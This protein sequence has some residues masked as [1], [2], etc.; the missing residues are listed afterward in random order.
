M[1]LACQHCRRPYEALTAKSVYCSGRCRAAASR[2]RR[3]GAVRDAL[4]AV[5]AALERALPAKKGRK[6]TT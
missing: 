3:D 1:Q 6:G 4:D 5:K 2:A